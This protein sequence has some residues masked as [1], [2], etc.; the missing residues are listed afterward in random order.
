MGDIVGTK[1]IISTKIELNHGYLMGL[2]MSCGLR[3]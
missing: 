3:V 2:S 1:P